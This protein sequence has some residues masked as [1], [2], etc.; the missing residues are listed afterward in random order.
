M[1]E[2][3]LYGKLRR[4]A[5][6]ARARG[7]SVLRLQPDPDE[8]VRTALERAGVACDDV[9]HIFLNGSILRTKNSMAPWLQ[10][11][12]A[13]GPGLDTPVQDGDRLGLFARDMALL[14]V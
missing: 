1:F 2:I 8:T 7:A 9:F 4:Y 13:V 14:V 3:H 11:Q 10:Y 6:D 12:Q 5:P